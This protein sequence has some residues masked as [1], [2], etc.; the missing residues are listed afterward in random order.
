MAD[1]D[2]TESIKQWVSLD[3]QVKAY[4]DKAKEV[5]EQRNELADSIIEYVDTSGLNNT[6]VKISDGKLR[7]APTKQTS[8]LTLS[9]VEDCLHKCLGDSDIVKQTMMY[10]KKNREV[11]V[12]RDI[13]R[14]Y[15]DK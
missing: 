10:I 2:F 9:Y 13:K 15:T 1:A 5:R 6:T 7:F 12:S 11:K 4:Y 14:T 8:S 3:N